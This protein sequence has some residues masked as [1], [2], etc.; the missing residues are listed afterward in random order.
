MFDPLHKWLGIPANEQPPN[1]YRLLG[2]SLFESDLDVIDAAADKHLAYL[3]NFA[4]GEHGREA[5]QLANQLSRV[6]LQ[7]IDPEQKAAYDAQLREQLTASADPNPDDELE[8]EGWYLRHTPA[9]N[10]GPYS[11]DDLMEAAEWGRISDHT[12]IWHPVSTDSQWVLAFLFE[13]IDQ[14]RAEHTPK[15]SDLSVSEDH[16][17]K[18]PITE[19]ASPVVIRT[20]RRR[21]S[22]SYG[23][24]VVL[25]QWLLPAL[26]L[27]VPIFLIA[28]NK[29]TFKILF[30]WN[31][32]AAQQ[33]GASNDRPSDSSEPT[34][35][36]K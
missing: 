28:T 36:S 19:T 8:R 20:K 12:E 23:C 2:I 1:H 14:H 21:R 3:H 5:E 11:L 6:R 29:A 9:E 31:E 35:S 22:S 17:V 15:A 26:V 30:Q 27:A 34:I 16:G 4:N 18:D 25:I 13:P 33:A 10:F 7:L 32:Q 24:F